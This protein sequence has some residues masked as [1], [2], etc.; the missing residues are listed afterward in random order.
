MVRPTNLEPIQGRMQ[1]I[2]ANLMLKCPGCG[3]ML[4]T[5]D[6]VRD[7]NVC[8]RCGHHG[9]MG[10]RARIDLL[11]ENFEE[12]DKDL[13]PRDP[14]AFPD[15]L[16]KRSGAQ[17][18]TGE[19]DSMLSGAATLNGRP[20][21]IAASDF[22]FMGGSMGSVFGEKVTR[23]FERALKERR[24]VITATS[25]GGA[26][27]QEGL[28]SLMQ[29]A[30]TSAAVGRLREAGLPFISLLT[31][32]SMAGVQASF[33]SLGDLLV[34]EPGAMIGFTGA[35]VIEQNLRIKLPRDFQSAEF[36]MAHGQ[37]DIIVPRTK[38]KEELGQVLSLLL[39]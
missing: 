8:A 7:L 6:Y 22:A 27:M 4:V 34:A 30:K 2:P 24:P 21:A 19:N 12:W 10:A 39:D 5:K 29:M 15:Y 16:P 26:R 1:E 18:K 37:I 32:P 31:D 23:L 11:T 38:L 13:M 33:A 17:I 28:M 20:I 35:R 25:T 36:Q 3:A 9:R 14:L